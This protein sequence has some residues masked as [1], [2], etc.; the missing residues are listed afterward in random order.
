[1]SLVEIEIHDI[2]RQRTDGQ[3]I[4]HA[5]DGDLAIKGGRHL[6]QGNRACP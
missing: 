2:A 1:M 5:A 3:Y 4:A 6:A